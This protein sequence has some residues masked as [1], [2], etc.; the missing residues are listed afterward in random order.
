[1]SRRDVRRLVGVP[2]VAALAVI[3]AAGIL[4]GPEFGEFHGAYGQML[5]RVAVPERHT[6]N[7]VTSIVFDYRGLDTMGEEF[8]CSPPSWEWCCCS[9]TSANRGATPA[10]TTC[11]ATASACSASR[12]W[13][14]SS[15]WGCGSR[16][17]AS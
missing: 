17:S 13:G 10:E 5:N 14:R 11:R 9:A 2:V 16:R 1:M 3:L 4:A 8:I 15:W 6:T 7:V 12:W